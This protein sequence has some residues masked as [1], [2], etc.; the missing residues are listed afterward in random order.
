MSMSYDKKHGLLAIHNG[1]A[2]GDEFDTNIVAADVVLDVSKKGVIVGLELLNLETFLEGFLNQEET[3]K[4]IENLTDASFT[5]EKRAG[6]VFLTI[7]FTASESTAKTSL[8]VPFQSAI[9]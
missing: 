3:E 5:A 4:I 1:F 9:A 7:T 6:G 2:E 8:A